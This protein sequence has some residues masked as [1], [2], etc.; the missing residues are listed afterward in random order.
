MRPRG[1]S[2]LALV[3]AV[4]AP[5]LSLAQNP[6]PASNTPP[7]TRTMTRPTTLDI[8]VIDV[9]G[10]NSTLIVT[11]GRESLLI[12][13]GYPAPAASRDAGRIMDAVHDASLQQIDHLVTTHWHGD[14]FGGLAELASRIP[15]REFIDHGLPDSEPAQSA[16]N[17]STAAFLREVY[18]ELYAKA[19]H[20]VVKPGDRIPMTGLDVRVVA[21]AGKVIDKPLPGAG[22]PNRYCADASAD[23]ASPVLFAEDAQSV[24]LFFT[25]GKFRAAHLGD[26]VKSREFALMCPVNRLG[27]VDVLLGLHHGQSTSNSAELVHA[28]HPRVAIMNNGTR[29]GGEPEVMKVLHTSPG[30][31]DLWQLHFSLLSG[32]EY[33][34]PGMFI[35][36]TIDDPIAAM[37]VAP[38]PAPP[39]GAPGAPVHSGK[40]Y[41]IKV[42][43]QPD[44]T[45]TVTNQRNQFSKTYAAHSKPAAN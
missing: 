9:E 4:C 8:Y 33:T 39:Q 1:I 19:K 15:V 11:P 12:D 20:T 21:S 40:A 22:Q 2:L 7:R 44:G 16:A 34:Q 18:P 43:A 28:L 29:K 26:L 24:G 25:F 13:T 45:F 3:A 10:G 37:P 14:H 32:Q 23:S 30:L 5:L 6:A 31:E 36:N 35:A 41:W 38:L 27:W 42:S 17:A